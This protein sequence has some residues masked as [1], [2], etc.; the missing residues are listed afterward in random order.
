MSEDNTLLIYTCGS[1]LDTRNP[2]YHTQFQTLHDTW[3]KQTLEGTDCWSS[4]VALTTA[5]TTLQFATLPPDVYR[6][7]Q[8]IHKLGDGPQKTAA[9]SGSGCSL[10]VDVVAPWAYAQQ[11]TRLPTVAELQ[12]F[13]QGTTYPDAYEVFQNLPACE[14]AEWLQS[15]CGGDTRPY[16]IPL[17]AQVSPLPPP[18]SS[19]STTRLSDAAIAGIVL[20]CVVAF[21]LL[22]AGIYWYRKRRASNAAGTPSVSEDATTDPTPPSTTG[23]K[24]HWADSVWAQI[25]GGI[26]GFLGLLLICMFV[27]FVVTLV[28]VVNTS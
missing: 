8:C 26:G 21:I 18:P 12:T 2:A 28:S 3:F 5:T 10:C 6:C 7:G 24:K 9:R 15:V 20:I 4:C 23:K 16:T 13:L 11:N 25:L 27:G 14:R 1:E 17:G 19:A 22:V